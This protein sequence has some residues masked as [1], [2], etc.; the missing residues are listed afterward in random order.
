MSLVL[1]SRCLLR[2]EMMHDAPQLKVKTAGSFIYTEGGFHRQGL[3][4]HLYNGKTVIPV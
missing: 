3:Y 1:H 4:A 2:S